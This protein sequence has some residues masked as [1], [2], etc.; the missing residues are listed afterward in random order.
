MNHFTNGPIAKAKLVPK[1]RL[2]YIVD[3]D[4]NDRLRSNDILRDS[5]YRTVTFESG[6]K[7]LGETLCFDNAC[8]LLDVCMREVD[9]LTVVKQLTRDHVR[10]PVI[11]LSGKSTLPVAVE[12]MKCGAID[13]L[14]K[15][16]SRDTLLS[17]LERAFSV[18]R[19]CQPLPITR[20]ELL[21]KVTRREG[22]VLEL[23]AE[24][25]PNKVVAFKLGIA[26]NTV[27]VHRQKLMKRLGIKNFAELMRLAVQ[28][29]I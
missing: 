4:E 27:E 10:C 22:Q 18:K 11:M 6:K 1:T 12:A 20:H 9:G 15:P 24:G 16:V 23:L 28:A 21:S 14:E 7:F 3:D 19:S 29:G 5:T 13:F 2:V 26:E 25:H 8:V 17:A